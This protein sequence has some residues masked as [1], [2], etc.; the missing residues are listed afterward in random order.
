M[1]NKFVLHFILG[2]IIFP[3]IAVASNT[4][5]YEY[6]QTKKYCAN[7]QLR[8]S[9]E[10]AQCHYELLSKKGYGR[11]YLNVREACYSRE[12]TTYDISKC[13]EEKIC[14]D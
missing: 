2:I 6:I 12:K 9:S 8:S 11:Q 3:N 1:K 5:R 7:L 13:V 10:I 14:Q 4:F